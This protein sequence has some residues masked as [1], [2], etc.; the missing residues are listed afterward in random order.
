ME[1]EKYPE[2]QPGQPIPAQ[3][4]SSPAPVQGWSSPPPA[5]SET[6]GQPVVT[7]VVHVTGPSWGDQPV[8][9]VCT[10]CQAHMTT[11]TTTETGVMAWVVAGLL[12]ALGLWCCAP[13][14]LCTDSLQDVTHR[15]ANCGVV[16][17]RCK[18]SL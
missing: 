14:P 12:C 10:N 5:Y 11:S 8:N 18:G 6:V 17:G 2:S 7:Q 15:C 3:V 16:V 1:G 4:W 13:I 9:T